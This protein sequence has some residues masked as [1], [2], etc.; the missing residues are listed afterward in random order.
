MQNIYYIELLL[1]RLIKN[2]AVMRYERSFRKFFALFLILSA[3][4]ISCSKETPSPVNKNFVSKEIALQHTKEYLSSLVDA[5]S[6]TNPEVLDIKPLIAYDITVYKIV[7][8][9]TVNNQEI[10]A[11]GLVCVPAYAG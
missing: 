1:K 7:Y 6:V 4:I 11:S 5:V 8:K 3:F 10:N 2:I 9:T